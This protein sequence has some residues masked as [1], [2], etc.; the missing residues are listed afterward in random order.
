MFLYFIDS[1]CCYRCS[2]YKQNG[3]NSC[4]HLLTENKAVTS[5]KYVCGCEVTFNT[6]PEIWLASVKFD[7]SHGGSVSG[8]IGVI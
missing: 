3:V 8:L 1:F 5:A 4:T 7:I 6:C 2:Y